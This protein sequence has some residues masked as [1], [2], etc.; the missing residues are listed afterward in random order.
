MHRTAVAVRSVGGSGDL[1][2]HWHWHRPPRTARP[3]PQLCARTLSPLVPAQRKATLAGPC[4]GRG[5]TVEAGR[6]KPGEDHDDS[7]LAR[8]SRFCKKMQ[9]FDFGCVPL[10]GIWALYIIV[11]CGASRPAPTAC[12]LL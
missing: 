2:G 11:F 9:S 3:Q 1:A 12:P 7:E 10:Q 4:R 5:M 6:E 8:C